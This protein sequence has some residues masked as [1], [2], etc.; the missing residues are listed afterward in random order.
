MRASVQF[1]AALVFGTLGIAACG[2]DSTLA[3]E[4]AAAQETTVEVAPVAENRFFAGVD[5]LSFHEDIG[6]R[7][8]LPDPNFVTEGARTFPTEVA[9]GFP[10]IEYRRECG[11]EDFVQVFT[12]VSL[13]LSESL[14]NLQLPDFREMPE[15]WRL[16]GFAP[17]T[18]SGE[19]EFAEPVNEPP[20]E[21]FNVT[22]TIDGVPD[23]D[24]DVLSYQWIH[25]EGVTPALSTGAWVVTRFEPEPDVIVEV[26]VV[27]TVSEFFFD[28]VPEFRGAPLTFGDDLLGELD[29]EVFSERF[30]C[31]SD[32][33]QTLEPTIAE[34]ERR[35]SN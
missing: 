2:Q 15:R 7:L 18:V 28:D 4:S 25:T 22:D 29:N 13:D 19:T 6:A 32:T 34:Y 9:A 3:Q 10:T 8:P 31:V 23:D 5:D 16:F 11:T 30:G 24:P 27:S 21:Q 14:R 35:N 1:A 33:W 26:F 20:I 17:G 12:T